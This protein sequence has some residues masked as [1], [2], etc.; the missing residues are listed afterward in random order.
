MKIKIQ[1]YLDWNTISFKSVNRL[2][3]SVLSGLQC[4][5]LAGFFFCQKIHMRTSCLLFCQQM[6][7]SDCQY[8]LQFCITMPVF[9]DENLSFV[10]KFP[11]YLNSWLEIGMF[12]KV[13]DI[14]K[15]KPTE[16]MVPF[17][18]KALINRVSEITIRVRYI[19]F[20]KDFSSNF[21]LKILILNFPWRIWKVR[22][23]RFQDGCQ[24]IHWIFVKLLL[25]LEFDKAVL[26]SPLLE[27]WLS[28]HKQKCRKTHEV[29]K[30]V[31]NE[32]KNS[33]FPT[34]KV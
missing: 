13:V 28:N 27:K 1:R 29:W 24:T 31:K 3:G 20:I 22:H 17:W 30:S 5:N 14:S 21:G 7:V 33:K 32:L 15:E 4:K 23:H 25:N 6:S 26:S 34:K 2:K 19:L 10:L 11:I 18:N 16:G 12:Q 8:W 9:E